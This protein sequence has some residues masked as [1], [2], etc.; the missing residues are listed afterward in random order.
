M[1][2]D[3]IPLRD[4]AAAGLR[5]GATAMF[6]DLRR[7]RLPLRENVSLGDLRARGDGAAVQAAASR[8]GLEAPGAPPGGSRDVVRSGPPGRRGPLGRPVAA[9]GTRPRLHGR[10]LA[11][12][13]GRT[14]LI[15]SHRLGLARRCDRIVV[16]SGGRVAEEGTHAELLARGGDYA[17]LWSAQAQWYR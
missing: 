16:L 7:Y 11:T 10:L 2:V 1:L 13:R 17:A 4:I 3:G 12:L 6:Q 5:A 8:G 9:G 14:A 15:V